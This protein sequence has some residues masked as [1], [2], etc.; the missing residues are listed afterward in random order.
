MRVFLPVFSSRPRLERLP[1]FLQRL[2]VLFRLAGVVFWS[3]WPSH[4][5]WVGVWVALLVLSGSGPALAQTG[6]TVAGGSQGTA[7][8]QLNF[9]SGVF[10]DGGGE[11]FLV[12]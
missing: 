5:V 2:L 11:L 1:V 6:T 10:V 12:V 4:G 3:R 8:N 7:A 9:P